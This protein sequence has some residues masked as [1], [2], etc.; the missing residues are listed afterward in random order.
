[1]ALI[2]SSRTPKCTKGQ[3]AMK[4]GIGL[5][6]HV[7]G[8][9][10]PLIAQWARRAE[11]HGFESVATADRLIYPGL[12]SIVALALAAGATSELALVT[13]VLLAPLYPPAIL[14]KQLA[15]LADAAGNRL[16][17]GIGVGPREDDYLA[18]GVDFGARGRLLDEEVAA[19]R[20]FWTGDPVANRA[21]LCPAPVR[22]PLLFGGKSKATVRRATTMGD[23]WI[24]GAVRDY[25]T[26]SAFADRIRAEWKTAGRS[27]NPLI[28]A[29]VN[30]ALGDDDL[31]QCGRKHLADYY[32]FI[33][34]Y[35]D[36]N[37]AD[38]LTSAQEARDAVRAY[39]DLGFDRLLFTPTVSSLD[40][41]DRLADA[42]L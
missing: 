35:A 21:P 25:P 7:A 5:P 15:S 37:V 26:Q 31:V 36:L 24:T 41:V 6:N 33:P 42:V 9:P 19:L 39:R 28:Q 20:K 13:N 32:G 12:D 10:G 1:V 22:I 16:T 38:L 29:A 17:I 30:F 40:Q 27:G 2:N 11:Q 14:A 8:V 34:D 4:I 18:A 3:T 23:G